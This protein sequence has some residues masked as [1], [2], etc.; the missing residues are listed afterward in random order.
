MMK[1][2]YWTRIIKQCTSMLD[3]MQE[4]NWIIY[5]IQSHKIRE[6]YHKILFSS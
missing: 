6:F 3:V 2:N 5:D 4:V 1:D